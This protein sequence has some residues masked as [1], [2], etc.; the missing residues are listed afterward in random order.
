MEER[1][2][3]MRDDPAVALTVDGSGVGGLLASVFGGE[4]TAAPGQ[5]AHCHTVSIVGTMRAYTRGPGIVLRCP[6]CAEV[7]LRIVETPT[8]TIVDVSGVSSLR[9]ERRAGG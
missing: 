2:A 4:M 5:C 3:L 1:I 6:A 8:A 9:I 7:V